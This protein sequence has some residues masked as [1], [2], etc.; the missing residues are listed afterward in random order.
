MLMLATAQCYAACGN[1]IITITNVPNLGGSFY[2]VTALNA[3]GQIAGYSLSAG[4]LAQHAFRFGPAGVTD[5]GTLGGSSSIG[6]ALNDAGQVAG[7]SLLLGDSES[8]GF[9]F[10]GTGL[11]D[12]GAMGGI[13][14]TAKA[15]NN[16]GQVTGDFQ[17]LGSTVEAF[18]YANG[19]A[20]SLGH[21]GG[22]YSRAA[23]INQSG[24]IV[25]NSLTDLSDQH[26]FL[27]TSGTMVDLG[28]L[29]SGYSDALA[30]NDN[31]V[32]VGESYLANGELHG[33]V[34]SNGGMTDLGTLGGTYSSAY[35]VNNAGQI[36]GQSR[37]T[38]DAQMNGF[39]YNSGIITDL[40]TLGGSFSTPYA[41]NNLGQVVGQAETAD[42]IAHAFLRQ[43]GTMT[44]LNTLLPTNS[45]WELDSAHFLNNGGRIVGT[46]TYNG[47]A[48]WFIFDL[49]GINHPPVADAGSD[50]TAECT[51][52]ATLDG[53][54]SSD[55]DGDA[56]TYEWSEN[57]VILGT[58][59]TLTASFI[60]GSHKIN[61]KVSDPCGE[62]SQDSVVL[63]LGDSIAPLVTCPATVNNNGSGL[64]PDISSLLVVSD[65]CTPANQLVISQSP[66]AGTVLSSGQQLVTMTVT[67]A[68]GN[69][70]TCTTTV[71]SGD[72]QPPVIIRAPKHAMVLA[73]GDCQGKVP[74]FTRFVV[75]RDNCTP[76]KSLVI[77]QTPAAGSLLDKGEYIVVV[78]V[79]DAAGNS[80]S[81]GVK[82]TVADRTPP[83][84]QKVTVTPNVLAPANGKIVQVTVSVK[85]TDNCDPTPKS[86]IIRILCDEP[87]SR[88][89]I[90]VTGDLTVELSASNNARGNGRVYTI[91]L[92]CEDSAGNKAYR[93]VTVCVPKQTPPGHHRD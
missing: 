58:N 64:V 27:H 23:A 54:L 42:G 48:Q 85:A 75:A 5:L 59:S 46:G 56:L 34:Y 74:N 87:T 52:V 80:T 93:S 19:T 11:V 49:G 43:G 12:L 41:I 1:G 40:G 26:A 16:A 71:V 29:G 8:H 67:D 20:T 14:S 9:L 21:L 38:D 77:T 33:F 51:N 35:Q 83:V 28:S 66:A 15:V 13:A 68:S 37:T 36:I 32:V 91:V 79:T 55:P 61:L 81:R 50:Q 44:D 31:D 86:K 92:L 70:A 24:D 39:I 30:L 84:I 18:V 22:F 78:T 2:A 25:G 4:D 7:E 90:T 62:T 65:N 3:T 88:K 69:A 73:N 76:T 17:T 72:T 82:L 57:G 89:D 60:T 10:D 45:G 63:N 6:L 53:T 47:G